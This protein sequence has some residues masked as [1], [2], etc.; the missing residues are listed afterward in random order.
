V[1]YDHSDSSGKPRAAVSI[2]V[3]ALVSWENV[4]STKDMTSTQEEGSPKVHRSICPREVL[5]AELRRD[6]GP[7]YFRLRRGSANWF[8]KS[9]ECFLIKP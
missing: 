3:G 9:N 8:H 6:P 1:P 4:S 5:T 2:F 7:T